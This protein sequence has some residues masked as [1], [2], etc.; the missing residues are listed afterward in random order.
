MHVSPDEGKL[1][2]IHAGIQRQTGVLSKRRN[3]QT[4]HQ[5]NANKDGW[6][7][8]LKNK[9]TTWIKVVHISSIPASS[10]DHSEIPARW[11]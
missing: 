6:K 8:N 7:N 2:S 4:E 11:M 1:F 9:T 10:Y 5:G 3:N